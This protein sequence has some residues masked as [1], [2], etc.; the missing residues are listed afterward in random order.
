MAAFAG[1]NAASKARGVGRGWGRVYRSVRARA[2][3]A[4]ACSGGVFAAAHLASASIR[5]RP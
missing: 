5:L 2:G 3:G 4:V 1:L